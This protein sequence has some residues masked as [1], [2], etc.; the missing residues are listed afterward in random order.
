MALQV[1]QIKSNTSGAIG[2]NYVVCE[3]IRNNFTPLVS[4][5]PVQ[6]DWDI[7]VYEA[8]SRASVKIQ[9]KTV[10]WPS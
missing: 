5:N 9:V 7:V 4:P 6:S 3:L 1:M 10:S 2:E 8:Q